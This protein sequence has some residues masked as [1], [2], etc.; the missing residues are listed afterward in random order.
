[1][2]VGQALDI[3]LTVVDESVLISV[4]CDLHS[5]WEGLWN[6]GS[7][8]AEARAYSSVVIG[9]RADA[10]RPVSLAP[11]GTFDFAMSIFMDS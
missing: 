5:I 9:E 1:L 2:G 8:E 6:T 7:D 4:G 11:Q 3:L 10:I